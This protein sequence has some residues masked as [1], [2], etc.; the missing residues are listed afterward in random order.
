MLRFVAVPLLTL[1]G[2][3][4][5]R[6]KKLKEATWCCSV[7]LWLP[8]AGWRKTFHM[9]RQN[10][11]V[12]QMPR[13]TGVL[14]R[15]LNNSFYA[16]GHVE[17]W[18]RSQKI[19][20]NFRRVWR[21]RT[22]QV[23]RVMPDLKPS[24]LLKGSFRSLLQLFRRRKFGLWWA[25]LGLPQQFFSMISSQPEGLP[26]TLRPRLFKPELASHILRQFLHLR[27]KTLYTGC[28]GLIVHA[29]LTI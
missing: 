1:N 10:R 18:K 4:V 29:L 28:A 20:G 17:L 26:K 9:R 13:Y 23:V 11:V 14:T 15:C 27:K 2:W 7:N 16:L 24:S 5:K 22:T 21:Y 12:A 25:V 8:T 3:F 19:V 6:C